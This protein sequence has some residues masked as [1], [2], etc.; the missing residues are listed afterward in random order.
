MS[1][2]PRSSHKSA[3]F[4]VYIWVPVAF[5]LQKDSRSEAE[6]KPLNPYVII[7]NIKWDR[8][9]LPL[10]TDQNQTIDG[11]KSKENA[12]GVLFVICLIWSK[13]FSLVRLEKVKQV[14][15]F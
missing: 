8:L 9:P 7:M 12:M 15:Q 5:N 2:S 1:Y 10:Q 4:L 14:E 13:V 11:I 6:K 3:T